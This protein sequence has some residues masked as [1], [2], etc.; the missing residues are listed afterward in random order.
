MKLEE[1]IK[2]YTDYFESIGMT[3]SYADSVMAYKK[4]DDGIARNIETNAL[5]FEVEYKNCFYNFAEKSWHVD[6]G[7]LSVYILPNGL[8]SIW[9]DSMDD[10]V[11]LGYFTGDVAKS[12][13]EKLVKNCKTL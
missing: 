10:R 3:V 9:S 7:R 12:I 5:N 1:K 4:G 8:W 13:L 6:T 2:T 11:N